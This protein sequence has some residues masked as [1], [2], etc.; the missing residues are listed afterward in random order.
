VCPEGQGAE[1]GPGCV[2]VLLR[3]YTE[4]VRLVAKAEVEAESMPSGAMEELQ[5]HYSSFEASH[6]RDV[7]KLEKGHAKLLQEKL[8]SG[9]ELKMLESVVE[10]LERENDALQGKV[11]AEVA[12]MENQITTALNQRMRGTALRALTRLRYGRSCDRAVLEWKMG[13][14]LSLED[15]K[16]AKQELALAAEEA[17]RLLES[18]TIALHETEA[19]YAGSFARSIEKQEEQKC[20]LYCLGV[21]TLAHASHRR[22]G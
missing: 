1:L 21:Q 16:A 9:R 4:S 20:R 13:C 11:P 19:R 18:H 7:A 12:R 22:I 5:S 3:R 2:P 17:S 8:A 6:R 14:K 15:S 10:R